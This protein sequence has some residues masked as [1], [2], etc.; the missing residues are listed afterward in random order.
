MNREK[1]TGK[2]IRVAITHG[3]FNGIGYEIIIKALSDKRL[4][5]LFTPI[6]YG[7]SK[8]ASYYKKMFNSDIHFNLVRK[9][10]L[11][12]PR[13]INIV[14]TTPP[15]ILI[16]VGTIS[17]VAGEM[18]FKALE[19]AIDDINWGH[20]DVL[21]TAPIN[22]KSIQSEQ[23]RY[24]GHTDYLAAKFGVEDY[25]MLMVS[26]SLRIGMV[27]GHIPVKDI[28]GALTREL[29]MSKLRVLWQS[30]QRDFGIV[31]PK[32]AVLGLNP[33]AGDQG[34]IGNEEEM[35]I[36]PAI[37]QAVDEGMYVFG[38]YPA[39]GFFATPDYREFD[40]VLAMYHD[41]GMLPFKVLGFESGVNFTAGLPIVRT[42]P[43]HGTAF[44]IAGKNQ[45]SPDSFRQAIYLALDIFRNRTEYDEV[46]A[47]PLL[48]AEETNDRN[49]RAAGQA[50]NQP[51]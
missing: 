32:I 44:N 35:S 7:S 8:I 2:N 51:E 11:A 27:T 3:D 6:V 16:E 9:A 18:A 14:N 19:K 38:P 29:I 45:A 5:E 31:K 40:A 23:F 34:L 20:A 28:A 26:G 46:H 41:Q 43:A 50:A 4:T 39:D 49:G 22:K 15:E 13:R 48:P 42:S 1:N 25:L 47:N 21:V 10:E 12:N 33:H 30:L 17:P 24:K 37:K 36:I